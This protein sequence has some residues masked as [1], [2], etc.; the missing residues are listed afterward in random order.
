MMLLA[1]VAPRAVAINAATASRPPNFGACGGAL[2]LA[3]IA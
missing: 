2:F 3:Y 1:A